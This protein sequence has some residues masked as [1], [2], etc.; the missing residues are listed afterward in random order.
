VLVFN[1]YKYNDLMIFFD[2]YT[3]ILMNPRSIDIY[4]FVL[5]GLRYVLRDSLESINNLNVRSQ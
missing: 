1:E 5:V 3:N 4:V 2:I